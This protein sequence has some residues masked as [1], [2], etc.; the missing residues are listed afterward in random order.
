[1]EQLAS[2]LPQSYVA[3]A[4]AL[5]AADTRAELDRLAAALDQQGL[6]QLAVVVISSTDGVDHRRF[7]TDLFN[8]WGIGDRQRNDGSLILLARA[9]RAAEIVLGSGIDN[10][11]NRAHAEAVM[12]TAMVPN[13]RQSNYDL[14]LINGATQLLQT[15]Y[16]QDLSQ[17]LEQSAAMDGVSATTSAATL[18]GLQ[19]LDADQ[20]S[21][22]ASTPMPTATPL[23]QPIQKDPDYV[24][25]AVGGGAAATAG[26]GLLWASYRFLKMLW[27]FT[28]SRWFVRRCRACATPMQWLSEV[29]D[30]DHLEAAQ[31]T[32]ERLGSVDHRIYR[33]PRCAAVDK[34]A[35]RAWFSRYQNCSSCHSR[36]LSCES[37]TLTAAT[38]G[39]TGVARITTDCEHCGNH[40]VER[41]VL[42]KLPP[43]SSS[44]SSSSF[45]GGSSS[46]GGA[47]GRW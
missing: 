11:Q 43:P 30:D 22:D 1:M 33:C 31:L 46:G 21:A 35:R 26:G 7:A 41:R 28:G 10:A 34:F 44:S 24:A 13:F 15:V 23:A 16:A 3:D 39:S 2:P 37:E 36:A 29:A 4:G 47:S 19:G 32:E 8:R 9:D 5:L 12:Q 25:W 42:P 20:P 38:R 45:G 6:G 40:S 27:W 18:T 17:V 14:A